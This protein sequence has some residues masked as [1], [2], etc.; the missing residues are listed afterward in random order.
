[1]ISKETLEKYWQVNKTQMIIVMVIWAIVSYGAALIAP[2]L[3]KIVIFGFPLGYYMGSQGSITV[4][5]LLN[6]YYSLKMNKVDQE[7]GVQEE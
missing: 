2:S 7:F 4:F 1:M 3:N 5:V 6:L